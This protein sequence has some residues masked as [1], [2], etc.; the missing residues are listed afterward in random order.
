MRTDTR[1]LAGGVRLDA[2]ALP[3]NTRVFVR[4]GRSLDGGIEAYQVMWG[5]IVNVP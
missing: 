2:A 4:A 5:E 3:V 1:F